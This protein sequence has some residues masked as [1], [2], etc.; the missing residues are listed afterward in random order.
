MRIL[1]IL[2]A[3][4]LF[5]TGPGTVR[6]A[7]LIDSVIGD[8][9]VRLISD[10]KSGRVLIHSSLGGRLIDTKSGTI[11]EW[12]G[13]EV[14]RKMVVANLPPRQNPTRSRLTKIGPGFRVAGYPTTEYHLSAGGQVCSVIHANLPLV[15]ALGTAMAALDMLDRLN[16]ARSGTAASPCD[17]IPYTRYRRIGWGLRIADSEAPVVEATAVDLNYDPPDGVLDIPAVVLDVPTPILP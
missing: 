9:P 11:Y 13:A 8:V 1:P 16:A 2:M 3:V 5:M 10:D 17:Q 15:T 7:V 6:A 4:F 14:P 12:A